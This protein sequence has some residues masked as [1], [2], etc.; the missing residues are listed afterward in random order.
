MKAEL[1]TP[2]AGADL[3]SVPYLTRVRIF[4]VCFFSANK[5][6]KIRALAK[7]KNLWQTAEES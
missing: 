7:F 4:R 1:Q 2:P 6:A 5:H 3:Q